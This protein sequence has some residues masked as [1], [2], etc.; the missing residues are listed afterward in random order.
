M[1]CFLCWS[2][3]S[4]VS[5]IS[6]ATPAVELYFWPRL[7]G[8]CRGGYFYL[9]L[10][11]VHGHSHMCQLCHYRGVF[12]GKDCIDLCQ[13][14]Q[15]VDLCLHPLRYCF[16]VFDHL[17][18]LFWRG[19]WCTLNFLHCRSVPPFSCG[20]YRYFMLLVC[21]VEKQFVFCP[22]LE[23]GGLSSPLSDFIIENSCL[24][25][26]GD[27]FWHHHGVVYCLASCSWGLSTLF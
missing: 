17:M 11:G 27:S 5:E 21:S 4:P 13:S 10:H 23:V 12:S 14:F 22:R 3:F 6:P 26:K 24:R 18:V 25:Q 15:N 8:F 7:V 19:L 9:R 16:Y 20:C 2:Y 1:S